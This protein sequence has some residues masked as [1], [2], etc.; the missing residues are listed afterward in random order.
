MMGGSS[1]GV[2]GN[3]GRG[4]TVEV[5]EF[6]KSCLDHEAGVVKKI[7]GWKAAWRKGWGG[8]FQ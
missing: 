6:V 5:L 7:E 2:G 8:L 4:G 1:G 3:I